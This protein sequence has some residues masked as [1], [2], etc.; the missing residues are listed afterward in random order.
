MR[1]HTLCCFVLPLGTCGRAQVQ[2]RG[3]HNPRTIRSYFRFL[4]PFILFT[5]TPLLLPAQTTPELIEA[6]E[7][8]DS[9]GERYGILYDLTGKLL[10]SSRKE[11]R[12]LAINFSK[13]LLTTSKRLNDNKL[14]GPAAYTLALAYRNNRDDRNTDKFMA[15]A[16]DYGM[17][18][19]AADLIMLAVA[20]RNR[21]ATKARNYRE[22][23]AISQ[24]ALDYFTKNGDDRNLSA[25]RAQLEREQAALQ[26]RKRE[27]EQETR[28]LAG[29]VN[30]LQNEKEQLS[31][32]NRQLQGT[33]RQLEQENRVRNQQLA[34]SAEELA[35]RNEELTQTQQ[36]KAKIEQRVEQTR[37][38][39]KS[40]SR[41]ALE[42]KAIA[43]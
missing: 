37:R 1:A 17:K 29:E 32:S 18:A 2:Q 22:A 26:R 35:A 9:D 16:V 12:A 40:L 36:E 38:E 24:R 33:N 28:Q 25:L 13:Q 6:L 27:V 15:E 14:I 43:T 4:L 21:L 41:E 34:E 8:A 5:L 7:A 10:E 20:E 42:Q 3:T 19:G 31:G 23:A 11:D 39:I 30:R